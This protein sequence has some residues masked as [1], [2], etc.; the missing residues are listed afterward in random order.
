LDWRPN[1]TVTLAP[2]L[3]GGRYRRPFI[4]LLYWLLQQKIDLLDRT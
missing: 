1:L 4:D 3:I 2:T